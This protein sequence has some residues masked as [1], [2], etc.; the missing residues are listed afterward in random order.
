MGTPKSALASR[1]VSRE[2]LPG[3]LRESLN[4]IGSVDPGHVELAGEVLQGELDHKG[5]GS[6][7]VVLQA[8]RQGQVGRV[9]G[10]PMQVPG[11]VAHHDD[12]GDEFFELVFLLFGGL[13]GVLFGGGSDAG[14]FPL[15]A[16]LDC[17]GEFGLAGVVGDPRVDL[18]GQGVVI[19]PDRPDQALAEDLPTGHQAH[20]GGAHLLADPGLVDLDAD[21]VIATLARPPRPGRVK[22]IT[23][24]PVCQRPAAGQVLDGRRHLL[25]ELDTGALG[26]AQ[27][28]AHVSYLQGHGL[29]RYRRRAA[30]GLLRPARIDAPA[31]PGERGGQLRSVYRMRL[32]A[33]RHVLLID[34]SPVSW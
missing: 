25:D 27:A 9:L 30:V 23:A 24:L 15:E 17:L 13:G 16:L 8:A 4:K 10:C 20:L 2:Y 1:A 21:V 18:G 34:N 31:P 12:P 5:P 6:D 14:C 33:V 19:G 32:K 22:V 7:D 29:V 3:R 28:E 26:G 11:A